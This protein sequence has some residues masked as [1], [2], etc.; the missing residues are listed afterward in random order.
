MVREK[1]TYREEFLGGIGMSSNSEVINNVKSNDFK[2]FTKRDVE[3]FKFYQL[4]KELYS[5]Q[6]YANLSNN[7]CVLYAML[8][9]RL[10]LSIENNWVDEDGNI[11]F[12]YTRGYAAEIIRVATRTIVKVFKELVDVGLLYEK[13]VSMTA[14]KR[15]YLGQII[16]DGKYIPRSEKSAPQT[17]KSFTSV[18]AKFA[19]H[20]VQNLHPNDTEYKDTDIN[21]TEL[22]KDICHTATPY[23]DIVNLFNATCTTLPKVKMIS[24]KRKKLIKGVYEVLNYDM[25][26]LKV[27]FIKVSKSDFLLGKNKE[28]WTCNFDW[29][30]NQNN[31][32][33][34]LEGNYDNKVNTSSDTGQAYTTPNIKGYFNNYEQ[35]YY[36]FDKLEKKLLGWD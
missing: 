10:E 7:A 22:N 18:R 21:D 1:F 2:F 28:S 36:D 6:R 9:D 30:M 13:R 15:L 24:E 31:M 4:P 17:G 26:S 3:R 35:R 11:Y 29:I 33:K 20:E 34:I 14:P 5:L 16:N 8:K 32:I 27:L 23:Q 25:D 19:P 12:I